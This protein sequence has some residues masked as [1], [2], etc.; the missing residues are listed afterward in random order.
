M[1]VVYLL[2]VFFVCLFV[3][4]KS[5]SGL[6]EGILVNDQGFYSTFCISL[7]EGLFF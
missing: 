6:S 5:L 2:V 4:R 1:S 7:P 3:L